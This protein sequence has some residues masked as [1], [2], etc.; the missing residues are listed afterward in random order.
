MRK[1]LV[2]ITSLCLS[3]AMFGCNSSQQQSKDEAPQKAKATTAVQPAKKANWVVQLESNCGEEIDPAQCVASK[4]FSVDAEGKYKLGGLNSEEPVKQG[5]VSSEE[6]EKLKEVLKSTLSAS[7][8]SG[9]K[10]V[11]LEPEVVEGTEA[12]IQSDDLIKIS[13]SGEAL[14]DLVQTQK[15]EQGSRLSF[16]MDKQEDAMAVH[17]AMK[18]LA[19]KYYLT[20]F[21]SANACLDQVD[22]YQARVKSAQFCATDADCSYFDSEFNAINGVDSDYVATLDFE[23]SCYLAKAPLVGNAQSINK[24]AES[25]RGDLKKIGEVCGDKKA[26]DD[27]RS[28][29]D[30]LWTQN[31]APRCDAGV[32]KRQDGLKFNSE[33]YPSS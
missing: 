5:Q 29:L 15:Q 23:N 22:A 27:C 3:V 7:Q 30:Y 9:K 28:E 1:E 26:K 17:K 11:P 10:D 21:P 14:Q 4:G 12:E 6:L 20:P 25:L 2:F 32:C 18:E 31:K 19:K 24:D 16:S 33:L 13:R 8:L